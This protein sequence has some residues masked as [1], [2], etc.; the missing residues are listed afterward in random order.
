M[1]GL[2][3]FGGVEYGWW[4]VEVRRDYTGLRKSFFVNNKKRIFII[5]IFFKNLEN[6]FRNVFF[7]SKI[8]VI[9]EKV[10][11]KNPGHYWKGSGG[12]V[13]PKLCFGYPFPETLFKK[14]FLE[15]TEF[16][17]KKFAFKGSVNIIGWLVFV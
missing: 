16:L 12:K 6:L 9:T 1:G 5:V 11:F 17:K 2:L 14:P 13:F 8:Q 10:F 3:G 15:C 7:F 4:C